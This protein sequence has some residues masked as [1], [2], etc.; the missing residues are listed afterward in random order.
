MEIVR[1]VR[2]INPLLPV[3]L[4][5]GFKKPAFKEKAEALGV[6]KILVKPVIPSDMLKEIKSVLNK[7]E[8]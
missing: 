6:S 3:I 8:D 4:Y 5:S 7:E 1:H 2:D